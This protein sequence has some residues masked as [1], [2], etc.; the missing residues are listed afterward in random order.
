MKRIFIFGALILLLCSNALCADLKLNLY[1]INNN[2]GA[3][4]I[5]KTG[6]IIIEQQYKFAFNFVGDYAIVQ[7]KS[8]KYGIIDKSGKTV[9]DFNYDELDNLSDNFV[10]YKENNKFGFIDIKNNIKSKPNFDKAKKFSEGLL[11]VNVKGKWGFV[12]KNGKFIVEPKYF[13]VGNFSE[14]LASVSDSKFQTSGYINKKG[15]MT[16]SFSDNNLE[17]KE[18]HQGLAPIIKNS[19]KS[20]SYINKKGKIVIDSKNIA[21]INLY[22]G[23]FY[24]GVNVFYIDNDLR[25]IETGFVDKKGKIKYSML[26]SIPKDVSE[27]EFSAFDYFS[28][29]M[30]Q[31]IYD[32]KTGYI[33]RNFR[34]A[35]PP[36]YEF[37]RPFINDLAYVKF[38]DKEGYINKFGKWVW[39][40]DREGM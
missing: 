21:P 7:A 17:P 39:S 27:G 37:A 38:E 3:G 10:I 11:A 26:F 2:L 1:P 34:L 19:E 36:V 18:F 8:G 28:S 32:Y 20:C 4:Y 33:D 9:V 30:A 14:G 25:N 23:D 35:I 31:F 40:K 22:C 5:D 29:G 13:D 6:K 15:K 16:I 12:N 24:E